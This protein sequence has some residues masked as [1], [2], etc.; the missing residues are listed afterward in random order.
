MFFFSVY[1]G[2]RVDSEKPPKISFRIVVFTP[3]FILCHILWF[4]FQHYTPYYLEVKDAGDYGIVKIEDIVSV[5][6]RFYRA[7]KYALELRLSNG[8]ELD[9]NYQR[10]EVLSA[11]KKRIKG[12][13]P[14][15]VLDYK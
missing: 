7:G 1:L 6:R 12:A 2:K 3:I 4:K 15:D 14:L 13:D 9:W 5:E 10:V 8:S 11:S